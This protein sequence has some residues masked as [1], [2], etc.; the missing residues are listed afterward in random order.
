LRVR[1]ADEMFAEL[2]ACF[3]MSVESGEASLTMELREMDK[4]TYRK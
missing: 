2:K 1:I 3:S 4:L